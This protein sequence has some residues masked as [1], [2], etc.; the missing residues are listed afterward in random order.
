MKRFILVLKLFVFTSLFG[1][2]QDY[3]EV[4]PDNWSFISDTSAFDGVERAAFIIGTANDYRIKTPILAVNKVGEKAP[5]IHLAYFPADLTGDAVVAFKFDDSTIYEVKA[6]YTFD[7][8]RYTLVFDESLS[9]YQF[10]NKLQSNSH[11][12]VRLMNSVMRIDAKFSLNG[13]TEAIMKLDQ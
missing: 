13:S 8:R 1:Y 12:A 2:T 4:S 6:K 5:Q 7:P 9:L 11:I 10:I 3:I